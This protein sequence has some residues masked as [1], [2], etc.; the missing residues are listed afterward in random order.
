[1]PPLVSSSLPQMA[2]AITTTL[3]TGDG[4]LV[5]PSFPKTRASKLHFRQEMT[6]MRFI[7]TRLK[8]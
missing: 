7:F 1:M 8:R 6:L 5:V 4:S 3:T 2:R